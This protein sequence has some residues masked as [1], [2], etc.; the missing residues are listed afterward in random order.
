MNLKKSRKQLIITHLPI[1]FLLLI[2]SISLYKYDIFLNPHF[3]FMHILLCTYFIFRFERDVRYGN[4]IVY[5]KIETQDKIKNKFQNRI[6]EEMKDF[7]HILGNQSLF[8]LF[9]LEL[10]L[11]SNKYDWDDKNR[12]FIKEIGWHRSYKSSKK[13]ILRYSKKYQEIYEGKFLFLITFLTTIIAIKND[14]YSLLIE[15][16][17]KKKS[18]FLQKKT[19]Q[20]IIPKVYEKIVKCDKAFLNEIINNNK[21]DYSLMKFIYTPLRR[22]NLENDRKKVIAYFRKVNMDPKVIKIL[23]N[24]SME[25]Y[26]QMK[27]YQAYFRDLL[28][29]KR[30]SIN[31]K[32]KYLKEN[33]FDF[34][35][36]INSMLRNKFVHHL[37]FRFVKEDDHTCGFK[38]I[39]GN[40]KNKR[41]TT[42]DYFRGLCE[43]YALSDFLFIQLFNRPSEIKGKM[44]W[45]FSIDHGIKAL[46]NPN[47][48]IP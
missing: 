46:K 3:I 27:K 33:G 26:N 30:C 20:N 8:H 36:W 19:I 2:S 11:A 10:F 4:G 13:A 22:R 42:S 15:S 45:R 38:I 24:I 9:N 40:Y 32:L 44:G 16:S 29:S 37:N 1:F 31:E 47:L 23:S 39:F 25:E 14:F 12:F 35:N 6:E 34:T 17:I 7:F 21:K 41:I 48:N 5:Y 28:Y 18:I 43:I